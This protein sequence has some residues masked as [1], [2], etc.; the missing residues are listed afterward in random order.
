MPRVRLVDV[1]ER[2]GVSTATASLV[3]RDKPGPSE[4]SRAAVREAAESLGYRTDRTA[5][6]LA[7]R[8][9]GL[10]GV[11]LDITHPWY[12]ELVLEIDDAAAGSGLELLLVPTTRRRDERDA[13]EVLLDS[14][15]EAAVLLGPRLA[16]PALAEVA[17]LLPTVVV[18]RPGVGTA[19]GVLA[20]DAAGLA[21][22]ADHLSGL[23]HRRVAFLDGPRGAV[24]TRRR[25]AAAE[26]LRR[27]GVDVQVVPAGDT[28][29]HGAAA[30]RRMR[31]LPK[32]PTAALA[33]N[34]RV[35][36]G[37][38]DAALRSGAAVPGDLSL[39]GFDDS[40]PARLP[41]VDLTSISQ[42]AHGQAVAC[43][44]LLTTAAEAG[45]LAPG[46]DVMVSTR[47]RVRGSTAPPR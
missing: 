17:A 7:R 31:S 9:T 12:A 14:R 46:P 41:T 22:A 16:D 35:A 25:R 32:Q 1:A 45:S 30:W 29:E 44:R 23:R 5:S 4:E 20:D 11:V 13:V 37:A 28:E 8:R 43:V 39:V 27:H 47:L 40:P 42:D 38:R 15:C 10:V 18:G 19:R 21:E 3:L 24:A 6:L 26:A 2:A 34:D 36:M 33:F